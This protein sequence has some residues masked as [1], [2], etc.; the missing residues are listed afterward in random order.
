MGIKKCIEMIT[1]VSENTED[2]K[3]FYE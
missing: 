1:E 3:K 2:Y